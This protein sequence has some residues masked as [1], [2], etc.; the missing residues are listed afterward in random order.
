MIFSKMAFLLYHLYHALKH[1]YFQC[2][3]WYR[4]LLLTYTVAIPPIPKGPKL[5]QQSQKW[6]RSLYPNWLPVPRP[7]PRNGAAL[8][9]VGTGGM[10]KS[11]F[12]SVF[13]FSGCFVELKGAV[14]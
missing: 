12:F 1:L 6:Y 8:R 5:G 4:Y 3:K 11:A 14:F 2:F 13:Y 7:V 9:G 10:A